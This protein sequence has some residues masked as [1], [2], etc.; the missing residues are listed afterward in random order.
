MTKIVRLRH[1]VKSQCISYKLCSR[2]A[3]LIESGV[4]EYFKRNPDPFDERRPWKID[5]TSEYSQ[6]LRVISREESFVSKVRDGG[7]FSAAFLF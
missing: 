1:K 6:I 4:E 2:V 5:P 7:C 3:E